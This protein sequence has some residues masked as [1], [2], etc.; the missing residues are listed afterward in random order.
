MKD[1][2]QGE[3]SHGQRRSSEN[4]DTEPSEVVTCCVRSDAE[5]N[6]DPDGPEHLADRPNAPGSRDSA[7]PFSTPA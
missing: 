7:V 2:G 3:G 1:C 4:R 5:T 6:V